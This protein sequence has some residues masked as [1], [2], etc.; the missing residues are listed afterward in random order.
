[1]KNIVCFGANSDIGKALLKIL[2]EFEA[3][4]FFL[5]SREITQ[6]NSLA[7]EL[8]LI[9]AKNVEVY[10]FDALKTDDALKN[11]GKIDR[12]DYL[13]I[14]HGYL[15]K[16]KFFSEEELELVFRINCLS[17]IKIIEYFIP[18]FKNQK[19]GKIVVITSVAGDRGRKKLGYYSAA[20]AGVDAYLSALRQE[21]SD[22]REL[23]ILTVKPGFV[24][25]KMTEGLNG[26]FPASP[27]DVAEDILKAMIKNKNILYTPWFWRFIMAFIKIIP[28]SV[29]K[30]LN[31]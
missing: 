18:I 21:M 26:P 5:L 2:A 25:T 28:E 3:S 16:Y 17:V 30:R 20:K 7:S 6:L 1:M 13:L 31:F 11:L 27:E 12:V 10:E 9:G 15:P 4:N 8:K 24:K 29:F 19:G 23:Q 14:C 22:Y